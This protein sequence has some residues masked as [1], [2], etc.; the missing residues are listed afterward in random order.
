[1]DRPSIRAGGPDDEAAVVSIITLAF[2]ADPM[3]RWA[4]PDPA[5]YL[6]SMPQVARAFGG[7]GLAHGSVDLADGGGAR[8]HVAAPPRA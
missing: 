3:A 7:N 8:R 5:K 6:A 1:M 2:A 4:T